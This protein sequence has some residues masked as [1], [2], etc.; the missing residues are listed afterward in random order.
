VI[1]P[2]I[3]TTLFNRPTI[4]PADPHRPRLRRQASRPAIA[5]ATRFGLPLDII[6]DGPDETVLRR[7]RPDRPF[8]GRLRTVVRTAV[9]RGRTDRAGIEDF[10]MTLPEVRPPGAAGAF[11]R[12]GALEIIETASRGSCSTSQ[13]SIRWGRRWRALRRATSTGRS[14]RPLGGSIVRFRRGL[15]GALADARG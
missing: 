1:H 6:G 15:L 9:A 13:P 12:G 7:C 8:H 11:A 3:K 10:G 4:A 14:R 2:P 5:A